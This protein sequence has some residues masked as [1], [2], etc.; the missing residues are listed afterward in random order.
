[1]IFKGGHGFP[2]KN[3]LIDFIVF[4]RNECN[5]DLELNQWHATTHSGLVAL[6]VSCAKLLTFSRTTLMPRSSEAFSSRTRSRNISLTKTSNNTVMHDC[7]KEWLLEKILRT[8]VL[9][10]T[11]LW[12][13]LESSMFFL[14]RVDHKTG[15]W[16]SS[17]KVKKQ[18]G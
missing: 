12:K 1:M 6:A 9:T 17:Q 16:V 5:V 3:K 10:R 2:L 7:T 8:E 15:S 13:L 18:N 4:S 11:T 14:F